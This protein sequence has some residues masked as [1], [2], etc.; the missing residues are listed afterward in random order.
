MFTFTSL[1]EIILPMK[2]TMSNFQRFFG[3]FEHKSGGQ[4]AK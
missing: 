1:E 3:E 4:S 2:L